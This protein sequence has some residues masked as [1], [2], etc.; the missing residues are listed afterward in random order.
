MHF[1]VYVN[2]ILSAKL[3]SLA[4]EKGKTRN[5]LVRE[6]LDLYLKENAKNQWPQ[7]IL[8]FSGIETKIP[9]FESLREELSSNLDQDLF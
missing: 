7:E 6:A 3:S 8:A 1:T 5:T 9:S 2:D 4:Q